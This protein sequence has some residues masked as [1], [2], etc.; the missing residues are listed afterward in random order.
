METDAKLKQI[1]ANWYI[2]NRKRLLAKQKIYY[3]KKK[4]EN[5]MKKINKDIVLSFN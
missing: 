2:R 3:I 5:S 4:Q 1:K